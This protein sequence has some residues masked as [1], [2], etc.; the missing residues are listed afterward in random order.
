LRRRRSK[1][2]AALRRGGRQRRI[3]QRTVEIQAALRSEH[4]EAPLV[5]AEAMGASVAALVAV[6]SELVAQTRRLEAAV[7][8]EAAGA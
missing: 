5:V 4:L 2:A 7:P 6:I 8:T 1:I 3:E